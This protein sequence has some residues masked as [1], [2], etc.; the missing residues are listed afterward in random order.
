[1]GFIEKL[2]I[3]TSVLKYIPENI[4]RRYNVF[5]VKKDG[6]ELTV[7]FS[8]NFD[9]P[10]IDDL[11]LITN[12][13]IKV[14][15][16]SKE[17]I[18]EAIDLY[19]SS[20][21]SIISILQEIKY[22]NNDKNSETNSK[23]KEDKAAPI[24]KLVDTIIQKAIKKGASDIHIEPLKK[25][26][27]VR[28]RIDGQLVELIRWPKH[29]QQ[30]VI[31]RIKIMAGI[32]ITQ[33]LLPQDGH[34]QISEGGVEL[35]IRVSTLPT[36]FG[37]KVVLRLFN[38]HSD[39]LSLENLGFDS[40][41]INILKQMLD[42]PSGI[43]LVCG[44]T[45]SGK[46]TTLYSMLS[47]LN[48]T[49]KNIVTLEDPVEYELPGVNQVQINHKAGITFASGLRSVL[50][51]DPNI[52]MVGEI[53]DTDTANIAVRAALTGHLVFST[54]HTNNAAGAIDRLLDMGVEPYLI[55]SCLLGVIA[56]RLVRKICPY[57]KKSYKPNDIERNILNLEKQQL[58]YKGEGCDYCSH[59]GYRGR[60]AIGEILSI[61][62][63][64]KD[65]IINKPSSQRIAKLCSKLDYQSLKVNGIKLV[66]KGITTFEEI[67]NLIL[68]DENFDI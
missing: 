41:Q 54:L 55:A 36:V 60:I 56:Q 53:R 3:D 18:S 16:A 5:P 46:T 42:S 39:I 12:M 1:M 57:C 62:P 32:D 19:Y 20:K 13:D 34:F 61:T 11:R 63:E 50:R 45:G 49:D 17:K 35:D 38:M 64:H 23:I 47:L 44:P 48:T 25:S 67:K 31:T 9:V 10:A 14:V 33:R 22:E 29:L 7:A 37:E 68:F 40:N 2:T 66:K 28:F 59:T 24:V 52:I 15:K 30:P 21:D 26:M 43:L 51:Q 58:L 27:R 8:D 65:L 4:A 6:N